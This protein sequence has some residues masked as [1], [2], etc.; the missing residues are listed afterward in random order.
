MG[1]LF[2]PPYPKVEPRGL[3]ENRHGQQTWGRQG[4]GV[5]LRTL[6][7]HENEYQC[8]EFQALTSSKYATNQQL[9]QVK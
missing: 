4:R 2:G 6:Y 3:M 1:V 5:G 8:L 9:N 7:T